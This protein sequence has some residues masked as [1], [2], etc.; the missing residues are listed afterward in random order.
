[1]NTAAEG[2]AL[3]VRE[4]ILVRH[5]VTDWNDTGRLMGRR[6]IPINGRGRAQAEAVARALAARSLAAVFASPQVRTQETAALIAARHGLPV[7]SEDGLAEVWLGRWQDLSRQQLL[8]DPDLAHYGRDPLHVCDAIESAVSVHTRVVGFLD[9]LRTTTGLGA[10]VAV[11]HG[12]P[13]RIL[14]AELLGMP[15]AAYRRLVID[16]GSISV[17]RFG[18]RQPVRILTLNWR[19]DGPYG[20][21]AP[22]A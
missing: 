11:S 3:G 2:P 4:L 8:D 15:L 14:L 7:T 13:L 21:T 16:P 5:G 20:E 22:E 1:M 18:T 9:R 19:P 12:D 17:V 6:P 10:V